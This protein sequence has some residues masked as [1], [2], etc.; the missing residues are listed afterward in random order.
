[1]QNLQ[2]TT[3][4]HYL[5]NTCAVT[6]RLRETVE[7]A[8]LPRYARKVKQSKKIHG[9]RVH[10]SCVRN[11]SHHGWGE[12]LQNFSAFLKYILVFCDLLFTSFRRGV[13]EF[14]IKVSFSPS[15]KILNELSAHK[16]VF[17][18]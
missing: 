17:N 7:P 18:F 9:C 11:D 12:Q 6:I 2:T 10:T 5:I 1:M 8:R 15:H 14:S 4:L 16:C 13:L 3:H